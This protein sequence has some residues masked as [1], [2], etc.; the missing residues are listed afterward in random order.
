[1]PLLLY[2][3]AKRDEVLAACEFHGV[4]GSAVY[5]EE[6]GPVKVYFSREEDSGK[7]LK[8]ELRTSAIEFNNVLKKLFHHAAI[9][10]FR[11]PTVFAGKEEL[12]KQLHARAA[13]YAGLLEKFRDLVQM[14]IR[15]TNAGP[16]PAGESGAQHLKRRRDTMRAVNDI[17]QELKGA[18]AGLS[19]GWRQRP[20]KDGLRAFVMIARDRVADFQDVLRQISIPAEVKVR[21]SGPW[22]VSEFIDHS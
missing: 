18:L 17:S 10:P 20:S 3:V 8:Q 5:Q 6:F 16:H 21:V 1:M 13:E 19:R 9:I 11:Y 4:A 14:D 7:W 22:P 2:C 15:V 12:T